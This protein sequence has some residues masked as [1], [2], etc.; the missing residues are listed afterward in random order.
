MVSPQIYHE[1]SHLAL[2][3]PATSNVEPW[4]WKVQLAKDMAVS[5]ATLVDQIRCA[6]SIA[7]A[8]G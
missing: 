4:P 8:G 3:C 7:L 5:G 6:R 1:R 2:A